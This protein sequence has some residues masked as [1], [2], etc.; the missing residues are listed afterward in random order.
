MNRKTIFTVLVIVA[1]SFT[2]LLS[3]ITEVKSLEQDFKP[4]SVTYLILEKDTQFY[5]SGMINP[6]GVLYAGTK[7]VIVSQSSTF[8]KLAFYGTTAGVIHIKK[9]DIFTPTPTKTLT[10]SK[11]PTASKTPIGVNTEVPCT[12]CPESPMPIITVISP[13]K[14]NTVTPIGETPTQVETTEV[15][16]SFT[17]IPTEGT[18]LAWPTDL[19]TLTP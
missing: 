19:P 9:S 13:T 6:V 15:P 1:V 8:Y 4:Q 12:E 10:P 16:V 17:P 2:A 18:P 11:T 7:L 14:T 3:G 5:D